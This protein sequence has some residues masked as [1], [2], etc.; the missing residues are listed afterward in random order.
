MRILHVVTAL[1]GGGAE[2]FVG[3]LVP[4]LCDARMHCAV[5][6][7]YPTEVPAYLGASSADILQ[8]ARSGRYDG[9]FLG[10][11]VAAIRAWRPDV[12]HTHMHHGT[13]WGRLAA[14]VAGVRRIVRTEHLPCD[15]AARLRGTAL[16]NRLLNAV[17]AAVVT[18]T[19][20][21]GEY[22]A[23]YEH[24]DA[25]KLAIIPNGVED[26]L[27]RGEAARREGRALL[28]L[29]DA[30]KA[31]VVLGNLHRHKHQVLALEAFARLRD[32]GDATMR[33]FFVGDGVD[34]AMLEARAH[35]L[36]VDD[37]VRFLGYRRDVAALLPAADALVM[38]SLTEGM[39][40]ALLEA[41]RAEVPIV[42]TPWL[43][44]RDL[45]ADGSRGLLAADWTPEALARA[46]RDLFADATATAQRVRAARTAVG[47][48]Y[49]MTTCAQRHRALYQALVAGRLAA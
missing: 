32:E 42:S 35:A 10:R 12:V 16:P 38:P 30:T 48:E 37:A 43:G 49:A 13:Y 23:A 39:P 33:L 3:A 7:V 27:A 15:P 41:M 4:R 21:Q 8:I 40:L 25:R 34:R 1:N 22:L 9:A 47:S 17:T 31:L 20:E 2:H 45:L 5:M 18:F 19:R 6:S 24:F 44:A 28:D 11:M 14:Y 26:A 29:D 36:A 46:T